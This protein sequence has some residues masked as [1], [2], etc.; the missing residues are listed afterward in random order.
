MPFQQYLFF[1]HPPQQPVPIPYNAQANRIQRRYANASNAMARI[2][3]KVVDKTAGF[4]AKGTVQLQDDLPLTQKFDNCSI[5]EPSKKEIGSQSTNSPCEQQRTAS[6]F[7][8]DLICIICHQTDQ[9][10]CHFNKNIS[11]YTA[12]ICFNMALSFRQNPNQLAAFNAALSSTSE[13]RAI[14]AHSSQQGCDEP[15]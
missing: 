2:A 12:S 3:Q 4:F 14:Q 10:P 13:P 5:S 9:K 7:K 8:A 6:F 1:L 15:P 11:A